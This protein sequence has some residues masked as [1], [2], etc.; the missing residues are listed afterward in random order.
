MESK[1]TKGKWR[2]GLE[3]KTAIIC[4]TPEGLHLT[5]CKTSLPNNLKVSDEEAEANAKLIAAA[6]EMADFIG[7]VLISLRNSGY[8]DAHEF[9]KLFLKGSKLINKATK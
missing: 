3:N 6:P 7:E 9:G 4:D 5:V 8:G 1:H 2:V